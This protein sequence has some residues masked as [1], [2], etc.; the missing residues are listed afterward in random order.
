MRN[1]VKYI[2][3]Y[4]LSLIYGLVVGIRNFFFD[5]GILPTTGFGIPVISVGNLAVGGTGKTPHTEYILSLL[6]GEYKLAV[7]SRG[8]KRKTRGFYLA[9]SQSGYS[10]LGDEAS[11]VHRKFPHVAVAVD[12]KRVRGINNLAKLVD[13]LGV[14][15]LDDAFQHRY[16]QPGLS[17]LLTDY[18]NLYSHDHLLPAGR[19]REWSGGSKRADLIVVTKCPD[20]IKPIDMRLIETELKPENNQ[21]LFFSRYVYDELAPLFPEAILLKHTYGTLRDLQAHVLLVAGIVSPRPIIE[22]LE[23]YTQA[24]QSLLFNDHHDFKPRDFL[25]MQAAFDKIDSESKI[26]LLTE[27]DAARIISNPAYPE[28]L[29]P[30]TFVVPIRVEILNGKETLFTQKIKS[31]VVENSRNR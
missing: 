22:Q 12:E 2:F 23:T 18:A 13:D 1:I 17:I 6:E 29:K 20:E 8:Y 30:Y 26:I 11:Q 15:V 9:D 19:L 5:K 31:Y 7:L 25:A 14:V 16:V 10:T 27:K 28:E 4:P 21:L 3:L 24:I